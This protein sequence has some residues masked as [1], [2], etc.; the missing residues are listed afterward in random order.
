MAEFVH[1]EI[2]K[3]AEDNRVKITNRFSPGYCQ[4]YVSEQSKLFSLMPEDR[5]TVKL[6]DSSLMNPVKSVSGIIGIGE[7][8]I[9]RDHDC[10]QCG[11]KDCIFSNRYR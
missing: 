2:R 10:L 7:K 5:L 9:F 1:N 3:V 6:S 11:M 4:W 8:V